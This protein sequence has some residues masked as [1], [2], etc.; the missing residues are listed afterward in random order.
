MSKLEEAAGGRGE[1]VES[2]ALNTSLVRVESVRRR[3][4]IRVAAQVVPR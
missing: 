1:H 3:Y 4:E 2:R